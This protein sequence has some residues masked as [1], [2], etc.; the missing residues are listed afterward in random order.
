[1]KA[2]RFA[3]KNRIIVTIAALG[4]LVILLIMT[5]LSPVWHLA[6]FGFN[7]WLIPSGLGVL[8]GGVS[9]AIFVSKAA[10]TEERVW[11]AVY[12]MVALLFT[13]FEFMQRLTTDQTG[14]FF[15]ANVQG[16]VALA[17]VAVYLF[18]LAYTNQSERRYTGLTALLILAALLIFYFELG[19]NIV[20]INNAR[21]MKLEAWG[22]DAR[23]S[24]IA[25]GTYVVVAFYYLILGAAF[26]RM[27]G[28]RRKTKNPLIRRQ[29]LLLVFA[30]S[31]P[32]F[33]GVLSDLL[34]PGLGIY[35]LPSFVGILIAIS[36]AMFVYGVLKYQVLTISPTLFSNTILAI[37]Q[38]AVV[39]TDTKFNVIF[40][41][42]EAENLLGI[43]ADAKS[44]TTILDLVARES[45]PKFQQAFGDTAVAE[46]VNIDHIDVHRLQI[47]RAH[48]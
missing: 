9:L 1:M 32:L 30:I 5:F 29:S 34:L 46:T 41:N 35:S 12:L 42:Q 19:T 10:R 40:V 28:F 14:A 44:K 36:S 25:S 18:T 16:F 47:G 21:L 20:F 27:L 37:M 8:L 26:V 38:E 11:L 6:Y 31:L 15:W 22:W 17:P 13:I 3:F 23:E 33:G 48:V 7:P 24:T 43:K 39:V 45:L 2:E 4:A